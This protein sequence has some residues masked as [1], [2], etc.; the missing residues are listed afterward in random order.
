V[1]AL[2]ASQLASLEAH[3]GTP[4]TKSLWLEQERLGDLASRTLVDEGLG[5]TGLVSIASKDDECQSCK[6]LL[7]GQKQMKQWL[8]VLSTAKIDS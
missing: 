3:V 5:K 1:H 7:P 6:Q 2:A 4:R 8:A